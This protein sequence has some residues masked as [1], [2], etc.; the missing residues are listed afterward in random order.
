MNEIIVFPL[1]QTNE[2]SEQSH[3]ELQSASSMNMTILTQK[4]KT[5]KQKPTMSQR[6]QMP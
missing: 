1:E 6:I 3:F 5:N 4:N 2:Q